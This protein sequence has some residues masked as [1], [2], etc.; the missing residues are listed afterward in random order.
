MKTINIS[1]DVCREETAVESWAT[2]NVIDGCFHKIKD[3][4]ICPL[5]VTKAI[6][7]LESL[8]LG[9]RLI[10]R[11]LT[12]LEREKVFKHYFK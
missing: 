5:C 12:K 10:K 7:N 9:T 4:D 3:K 8:P 11:G 2:Q 1:C 6:K